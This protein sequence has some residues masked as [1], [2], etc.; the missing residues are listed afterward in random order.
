MNRFTHIIFLFPLIVSTLCGQNIQTLTDKTGREIEVILY[1]KTSA[2]VHVIRT[3]GHDFVIDLNTLD[4]RSQH[5][6]KSW[7]P[8]RP[9]RS[10]DDVR[11]DHAFAY[12]NGNGVQ[13]DLR[14]A[15]EVFEKSAKN[16]DASAQGMLGLMYLDG[17]GVRANKVTG[18]QWLER[19]ARQGNTVAEGVLGRLYIDGEGVGRNYTTAYMYLKRASNKGY[20]PAQRDLGILYYFGEGVRKD[21]GK[22]IELIEKSAAAG[23]EGAKRLLARITI[24]Q[25]E[26]QSPRPSTGGG[27]IAVSAYVTKVERDEADV[28]FLE[29]GAVVEI[30]WGFLGFVGWRKDAILFK[31]EVQWKIWIEEKKAFKCELLKAPEVRGQ[32]AQ[33]LHISEVLGNGSILKLLD[34]SLLEVN[35][36]HTLDT[37]LWLGISDGLLIDES[38]L[39]NFDE[40]ELIEVTRL[41]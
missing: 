13:K 12:Y 10:I 15:V 31:E 26:Y 35:S 7:E 33:L 30:S 41:K 23:D 27:T 16:G 34:G 29:N 21:R 22:G 2:G 3:D 39:I 40:G 8:D 25:K 36:L 24:D 6:V 38:K 32:S 14:R 28:L 5:L 17:E 18:A 1:Q 20:V 11:T 37:S 19:S 9:L 4:P